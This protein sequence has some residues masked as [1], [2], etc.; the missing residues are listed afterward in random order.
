MHIFPREFGLHNVFTISTERGEPASRWNSTLLRQEKEI[1]ARL[2]MPN[3][4]ENNKVSVPKRLRGDALSLIEKMQKRHN[5]C[6]YFPLLEHYCPNI[7]TKE[8]AVQAEKSVSAPA[9]SAP[10]VELAT[11]LHQVSA[12]CRAAIQKVVPD[13]FWGTGD[14]GAQNKAVVLRNIDFFIRLQRFENL[15]LQAVLNGLKVRI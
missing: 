11:P 3:D 4:R 12:F 14:A 1:A 5:K 9:G 13:G 8:S 7:T 10:L 6:A 2:S 15:N